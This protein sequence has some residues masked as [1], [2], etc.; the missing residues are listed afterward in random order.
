[1]F[2]YSQRPGT[3]ATDMEQVPA[4]V[5]KQRLNELIAL[6]NGIACDINASIVGQSFEVLVEGPSPKRKTLMQG[7]SREFKM[8]HF[9]GT[10]DLDGK[11]VNVRAT[12]SH[13]WGLSGEIVQDPA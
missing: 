5:K 9:P 10:A 3:R 8:M 11:T 7:Y 2:A 4:Q 6:Q 13:L 1:M 12:S